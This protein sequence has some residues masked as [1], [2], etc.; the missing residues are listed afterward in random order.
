[1]ETDSLITASSGLVWATISEL[2]GLAGA[3]ILEMKTEQISKK[4]DNGT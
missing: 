4:R 2:S 3:I 1:L